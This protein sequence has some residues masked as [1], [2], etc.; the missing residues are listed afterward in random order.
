MSGTPDVRRHRGRDLPGHGRRS[1]SPPAVAPVEHPGPP[2]RCRAPWWSLDA[3]TLG[4]VSVQQVTAS[5]GVG[6]RSERGPVLI[7]VMLSTALVA[8]DATVI[9]TAVPSVVA[10]LG[11]FAQFPWLFSVY[12][13]AQAVT[14]PVYGKLADVFGR[15][16]VML[17]GIGLFLLGSVLCGLAWS[18]GALIAFRAVQGLGAGAVQPMS[19]TIVGDLYSLEERA[20]VQGYIASVWGD[21]LGRRPDARWRLLR[22]RQLAVDLLRQHPAL[23]GR[24]ARRSA[25]ASPSGSS[26]A[27][28]RST[29]RRRGAH[30]RADAAH[31][32]RCSR[33]ARPGR[34][35]RRRASPSSPAVPSCSACSCSRAA[36]GRP[37]RPAAA[38]AHRAA[39][40]HQ[41]GRGVRRRR[42][43]RAHL[44]RADLRAGRAGHRPAGRRLRPR[45]PHPRL[46]DLGVAVGPA[47]TCG[48][49][50]GRPRSIGASVVVG[51][52]AL[53]L[54]LDG[55]SSVLRSADVVRHRARHGLHRRAHADRRPVRG[56]VAERGVVTGTNMFFRSAGSAV[57]IAVFGAVVNASLGGHGLDTAGWP[58]GAHH[59]GA[60]GL[61]RHRRAGCGDARRRCCSCPATGAEPRPALPR[62]SATR[63]PDEGGRS[64]PPEEACRAAHRGIA[65]HAR[66][67][68]HPTREQL[69]G[70]CLRACLVY[71]SVAQHVAGEPVEVTTRPCGPPP[72]PRAWTRRSGGSPTRRA[73]WPASAPGW[74]H[75]DRPRCGCPGGTVAAPRAPDDGAPGDRAADGERRSYAGHSVHAAPGV[76]EYAVV[77]A[78]AEL[79][80]RPHPRG[81]AGWVRSPC[82]CATP[83]STS[84]PPTSTRRTRGSPGWT[85]TTPSGPTRRAARS[86]W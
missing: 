62:R 82:G 28:R 35:G 21:L 68:A 1:S 9:A 63:R 43:A 12:L 77:A 11:G 5:S 58:R 27:A 39:R 60:L 73:R 38:A 17:F 41:P 59:C 69:L 20:K 53:L 49:A 8:I 64:R 61:R 13:L 74:S 14:V 31:P 81:R 80:R 7:G 46:A 32:R 57:G 22:V 2:A 85:S 48:S 70:L 30:R 26:G 29:S 83:G 45:R 10:D 51:G 15:K 36:R 19:M 40:G 4:A 23:P 44:L 79:R 55:S 16:P 18:M 54:L 42:P 34:G 47:C 71:E 6:F 52:A 25:C 75:D 37:R 65:P 76:H 56:R 72:A 66:G 24:R 84:S 50:S 33:A 86:T 3:T 78:Q 67:L